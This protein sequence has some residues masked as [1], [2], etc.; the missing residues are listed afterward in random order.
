MNNSDVFCST[1]VG[2]WLSQFCLQRA[3]QGSRDSADSNAIF[4]K[5]WGIL[6]CIGNFV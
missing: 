2:I 4:G 5:Q 1:L 6:T 3:L